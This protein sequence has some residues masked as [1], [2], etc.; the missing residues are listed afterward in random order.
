M[1][2]AL[3]D[4]VNAGLRAGLKGLGGLFLS[5]CRILIPSRSARLLLLGSVSLISFL[6]MGLDPRSKI[7]VQRVG[8]CHGGG[9]H[10]QIS[11]PINYCTSPK[12]QPLVGKGISTVGRTIPLFL[13]SN[14]PK[15]L[16]VLSSDSMSSSQVPIQGSPIKSRKVFLPFPPFLLLH[17]RDRAAKF[18]CCGTNIP[19]PVRGEIHLPWALC[20]LKEQPCQLGVKEATFWAGVGVLFLPCRHKSHF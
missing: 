1:G 14:H 4:M 5:D 18:S 10:S 20:S 8:L 7:H 15:V 6:W 2:V 19:L 11:I 3:G 12:C 16:S 9:E 13:L 17:R